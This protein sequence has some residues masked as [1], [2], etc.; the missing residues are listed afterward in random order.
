MKKWLETKIWNMVKGFVSETVRLFDVKFDELFKALDGDVWALKESMEKEHAAFGKKIS[1][2]EEN[3]S[4]LNKPEGPP[5]ATEESVLSMTANLSLISDKVD[6]LDDLLNSELS[7]LKGRIGNDRS[8]NE[9]EF[10]LL[11]K[12][13][14]SVVD[15]ISKIDDEV[16]GMTKN[17]LLRILDMKLDAYRGD[18]DGK[19]SGLMVYVK[20]RVAASMSTDDNVEILKKIAR[21]EDLKDSIEHRR[22]TEQVIEER[23][24]LILLLSS[25]NR[26]DSNLVAVAAKV[27]ILDWILGGTSNE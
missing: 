26:E 19:I 15:K 12:N 5:P 21:L 22:S 1:L 20:D 27:E 4:L 6:R 7:L 23:K 17:Q 8:E 16:L 3:L 13:V 11:K 14:S 9:R 10:L 2:L 24:R 25:L 18:I